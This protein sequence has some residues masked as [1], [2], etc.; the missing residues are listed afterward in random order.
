VV[1]LRSDLGGGKTTFVRGLVRGL[2][3]KDIVT[4]PT[5]TLSQTYTAKGG[6]KIAHHDFYRL[7]EAGIM[8]DELAESLNDDKTITIVE[9]ADIV[10]DV[11]PDNTL[12]V[13]FGLTASDTDERKI[14]FRY[15]AGLA[16]V[17][18]GLESASTKIL[19]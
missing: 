12:T 19:P 14:T 6:I 4:S 16:S 1:E 13:E 5:F 2:G 8:A 11:L 15:P 7:N 10:E 18:K 3:S 9:W 17:I